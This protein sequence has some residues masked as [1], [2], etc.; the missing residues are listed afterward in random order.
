MRLGVVLLCSACCSS[1]C[2]NLRLAAC[3]RQSSDSS[4]QLKSTRHITSLY[5]LATLSLFLYLHL[6][7]ASQIVL[8][9][10]YNTPRLTTHPMPPVLP[11]SHLSPLLMPPLDSHTHICF[12]C[13]SYIVV[14]EGEMANWGRNTAVICLLLYFHYGFPDFPVLLLLFLET[15]LSVEPLI[16]MVV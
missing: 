1:A 6:R 9:I 11:L 16:L 5:G 7:C 12:I 2:G 8:F 10:C 14:W 3:S 13:R 15:L 4:T